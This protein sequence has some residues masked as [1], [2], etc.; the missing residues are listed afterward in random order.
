[1]L[2]EQIITQKVEA[3]NGELMQENERLRDELELQIERVSVLEMTVEESRAG[4]EEMEAEREQLRKANEKLRLDLEAIT[5]KGQ[6]LA[7]P[8]F[9][10]TVIHSQLIPSFVK[11]CVSLTLPACL[12]V[13]VGC[14]EQAVVELNGKLMVQ[15]KA[16]KSKVNSY[17]PPVSTPP[18]RVVQR[19]LSPSFCSSVSLPPPPVSR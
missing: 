4:M 16:L 2:L 12:C 17:A 5:E 1:M 18:Q 14:G 8:C 15:I 7:P 9:V 10:N 13:V 19:Q 11:F 3:S 6:V